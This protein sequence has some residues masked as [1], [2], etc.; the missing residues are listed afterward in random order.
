MH[1]PAAITVLF[2]AAALGVAAVDSGEPMIHQVTENDNDG[3]GVGTEMMFAR[4]VAEYGKEYGTREEYVKRMGIFARNVVRAG[5][6]QAM[7]P[8]ARHGVTEFMDLTEEEFERMYM[9]LGVEGVGVMTAEVGRGG[10]G[11]GGEVE[12]EGLP[13]SFDWREKGAVTEVKMQ[14][15]CGSC[16]AFSTTGAI[17]GANFIATGK[18]LN[19]SEQQLIDCDHVCDQK[20]KTDCDSGCR[21]G[22]M[23]NAYKYLIE[24][25]GLMEEK[26]YP[27][28]GKQGE[29]KFN[30]SKVAV[31][32]VNFTTIPV[33][34]KQIAA[35]LVHH[36]P[37]A[38]V[39]RWSL[40]PVDLREEMG[41]PWCS[42]GGLRFQGLLYSEVREQAILDNQELMGGKMGRERLLSSLQR[43]WCVWHQH[44]GFCRGHPSLL[45][46]LPSVWK[47]TAV[48]VKPV[49]G[50]VN[51]CIRRIRL[52]VGTCAL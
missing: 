4:F 3:V 17:E 37:L 10:V 8:A 45:I 52:A 34:E 18:L 33:D 13:E 9:G 20:K 48:F 24:A 28:T 50:T 40:V 49:I 41:Q 43:T 31:R 29:C 42:I 47:Y 12:V 30:S 51:M 39:H 27:Y 22:L 6:H 38:D 15:V 26:D 7:D 32:V 21:G 5:E 2:I 11:E 16:W 23:T 1:A 25:G 35:H 36:G 46:H 19:L 44:Y 14:G